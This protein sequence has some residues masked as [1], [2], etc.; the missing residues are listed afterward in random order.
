M[1]AKLEIDFLL[2]SIEIEEL[3]NEL[4]KLKKKKR[5]FCN[6]FLFNLCK[7]NVNLI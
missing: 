3:K 7:F 4:I 2:L 5:F 1:Y 6:N